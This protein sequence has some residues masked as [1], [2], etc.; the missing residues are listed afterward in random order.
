MLGD[1]RKAPSQEIRKGGS[2]TVSPFHEHRS[3]RGT[4]APLHTQ[5]RQNS[6]QVPQIQAPDHDDRTIGEQERTVSAERAAVGRVHGS[7]VGANEEHIRIG[8]RRSSE[9]K[10]G[11][12]PTVSTTG[13]VRKPSQKIDG[14]LA[15]EGIRS[16]FRSV[17]SGVSIA[18]LCC[19]LQEVSRCGSC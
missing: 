5:S 12:Y 3:D 16:A 18:C 19:H 6:S 10:R 8:S 1:A 15:P 14:C 13:V 2:G 9:G 17:A 7:P 4:I 11:W